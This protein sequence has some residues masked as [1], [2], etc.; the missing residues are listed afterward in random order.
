VPRDLGQLL[1]PRVQRVADVR[2][3][4]QHDA[5]RVCARATARDRS[6]AAQASATRGGER[7]RP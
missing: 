7:P 2:M 1:E 4:A 6:S 3:Q 5:R